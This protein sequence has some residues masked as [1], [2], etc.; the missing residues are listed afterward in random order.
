[1]NVL[2]LDLEGVLTPEIWHAVAAR[3]GIEAL[4]KT[5]RD[6]PVYADLMRLRLD[7]LRRHDVRLSEILAVVGELAPLPGATEFLAWARRRFQVAILSD[8]F[9]EFA[10]PLMARL[11]HPLLLCHSLCVGDDRIDGYRLRQANGKDAAVR[12]FQSLA[13]K[14]FAVGDSYNDIAMLRA[15]DR[16]WLFDAPRCVAEAHQDIQAVADHQGLRTALE[17][18]LEA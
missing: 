18:A 3:T 1:M 13:L 7:T 4:N 11:G 6:V 9:Y 8:T 14:V 12:A 10:M 15:A 16:S 2:C 17:R 5:T